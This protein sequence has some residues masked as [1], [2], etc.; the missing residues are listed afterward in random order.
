MLSVVAGRGLL[1]AA[2]SGPG[3]PI[4]SIETG[5]GPLENC[6]LL[7][8]SEDLQCKIA[9][10]TEENFGGDQDCRDEF[11]H[12]QTVVAWRNV[13]PSDGSIRSVTC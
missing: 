5:T 6:D 13:V 12:E 4:Q 1:D 2:R 10:A 3:E 7:P 9:T 11:G 8:Q